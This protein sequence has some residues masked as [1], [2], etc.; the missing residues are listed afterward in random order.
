[1]G[2][3]L[4]PVES[5]VPASVD[6]AQRALAQ[7]ERDIDDEQTYA[8]IK[9]IERQADAIRAFYVEVEEVRQRAERTIILAK[10]R[11][12]EELAKA[13][14]AKG[15]QPYQTSTCS[16]REQVDPTIREQVGSRSRGRDMKA[17]AAIPKAKM[18][19]TVEAL[20]AQGKEATP[21][22]VIKHIREGLVREQ[23]ELSRAAARIPGGVDWRRGDCRIEM[24]SVPDNSTALMVTDPP[25]AREA[26]PLWVWVGEYAARVLIPGGSAFFFCGKG[27]L[28]RVHK[29][30]GAHLTYR[31]PLGMRLTKT[32]HFP[33][34]NINCCSTVVLWYSKGPLRPGLTLVDDLPSPEPDKS[35]HEWGQGC[36]AVEPI[37][38][39]RSVPGEL[40]LD[41][42]AGSGAF[43]DQAAKMGRRVICCDLAPFGTTTIAA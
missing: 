21:T 14:R 18:L 22:G 5:F 6:G 9:L 38:E 33:V 19:A 27:W 39:A 28:P 4:Q 40:F 29:I 12:G 24:A 13:P 41:P 31:W 7:M 30:L 43:A 32:L 17:L 37:I 26:E 20:H 15:G 25:W 11:C 42:F 36:T 23:R 34:V 1:M 16:L 35:L 3:S 2:T 10:R 8:A